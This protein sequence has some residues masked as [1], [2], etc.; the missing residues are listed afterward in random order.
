MNTRQAKTVTYLTSR[1]AYLE[2]GMTFTLEDIGHGEYM[3]SGSNAGNVSAYVD[4]AFILVIV[5]KHGGQNVRSASTFIRKM[6]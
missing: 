2:D 5:G 3:L 1:I 6:L 4:S